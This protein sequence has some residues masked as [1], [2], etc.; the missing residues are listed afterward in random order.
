M[1]IA[2]FGVALVAVG[3]VWMPTSGYCLD[4]GQGK[5]WYLNYC[6][7]CHGTSGKGDGS[8]ARALDPKPAD[9]TALSS[10]NGGVFPAARVTETIYYQPILAHGSREMPVWGR[11]VRFAPGMVRARIRAIVAYVATLQSK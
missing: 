10:T 3:T 5:Y 9:L 8:V 11:A 4:G 6:A 1:K 2:C 7:S